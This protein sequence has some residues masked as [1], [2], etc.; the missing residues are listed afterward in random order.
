MQP[1]PVPVT[2][3]GRGW[4]RVV[5]EGTQ[6]GGEPVVEIHDSSFSLQLRARANREL[7]LEA[8]VYVVS[9]ALPDGARPTRAI[10]VVAGQHQDAVLGAVSP[11]AAAIAS[12]RKTPFSGFL[13]GARLLARLAILTQPALYARIEH[14]PGIDPQAR[15][16]AAPRVTERSKVAAATQLELAVE[17]P[18][19]LSVAQFAVGEEVP[20]NVVLPLHSD[21]RDAEAEL[22][23]TFDRSGAVGLS[24]IPTGN[25]EID[26]I[27]DYMRTGQVEAAA[28]VVEQA[29]HL[30]E[31]KAM[32][33]IAAALGGYA[34][35][36]VGETKRLHDWPTNLANWFPWLPDGPVIA[37]ELAA[38]EGDEAR[39][40]RW[41]VE[42]LDRGYPMFSD[43]LSLL[44]S[45]MRYYLYAEDPPPAIRE[46]EDDV[47]RLIRMVPFVDFSQLAVTFRGLDVDDPA[48]SQKPLRHRDARA[49]T[50]LSRG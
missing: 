12:R 24:A 38:R 14:G 49:W 29:E 8:G 10:S 43:G 17:P 6:P 4:L 46:R 27:A 39:A 18:D 40:S 30:L 2:D 32:N 9:V 19:A 47:R 41:F 3:H 36:R 23:V 11:P 50:A 15:P 33:P 13:S 42:A 20:T 26:L 25:P 16:E 34:L 5:V 21:A 37:G 31:R 1:Q 45:R 22:Q 35:L 7:L 28:A 44:A 48:G